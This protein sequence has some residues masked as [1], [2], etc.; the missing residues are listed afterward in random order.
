MIGYR[1]KKTCEGRMHGTKEQKEGLC[2]CS[3]KSL[4]GA[5][6]ERRKCHFLGYG[7]YP[8][9]NV[10]LL[11]GLKQMTELIWF[12]ELITPSCNIGLEL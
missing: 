11:K 2:G 9:F 8:K 4:W 5:E 12:V 3:M 7:L 10:K 1:E 6:E